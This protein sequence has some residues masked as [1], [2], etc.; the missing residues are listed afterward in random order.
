MCPVS[1]LVLNAFL[2][3]FS[4]LNGIAIIVDNISVVTNESS[5]PL[6]EDSEQNDPESNVTESSSL[7]RESCKEVQDLE[8]LFKDK[9]DFLVLCF[10][11]LTSEPLN[12]LLKVVAETCHFFDICAFALVILS[13]GKQQSLY[14][15]NNDIIPTQDVLDR[16]SSPQLADKSKIF[17]FETILIK[18][19]INGICVY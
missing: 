17:I 5:S 11:N 15:N 1:I 8:S 14:D 7:L 18:T 10:N 4:G 12:V 19:I 9:L 16:F 3:L 2:F 13:K 6:R